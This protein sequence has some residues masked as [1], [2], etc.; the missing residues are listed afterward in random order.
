MFTG[1]WFSPQSAVSSHCSLPLY[2]VVSQTFRR[3][4]GQNTKWKVIITQVTS[5]PHVG[6]SRLYLIFVP[7]CL[8]WFY[9]FYL[10]FNLVSPSPFS[11]VPHIHCI[12][13][14]RW[15]RMIRKLTLP[16]GK[17][18]TGLTLDIFIFYFSDLKG[19][20][21]NLIRCVSF[22]NVGPVQKAYSSA[23]QYRWGKLF[24]SKKKNNNDKKKKD[25]RE[26]VARII[27]DM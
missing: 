19:N 20:L 13:L 21:K 11:F 25:F 4:I 14:K 1:S 26:N 22:P 10:C 8:F 18:M 15:I 9:F 5:V 12:T 16:G 3:Q 17:A 7:L 24:F 23:I 2:P 6:I 27:S